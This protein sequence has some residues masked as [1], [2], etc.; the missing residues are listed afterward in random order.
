MFRLGPKHTVESVAQTLVA[1]LEDGSIVLGRTPE[2]PAEPKAPTDME[3]LKKML[4]GLTPS[5]AA[6]ARAILDSREGGHGASSVV[7]H[8]VVLPSFSPPKRAEQEGKARIGKEST[9]Q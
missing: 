5:E 1:G 2:P 7:M 6:A 4:L 9:E 3:L 8:S